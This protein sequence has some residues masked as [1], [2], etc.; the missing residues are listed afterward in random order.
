LQLRKHLVANDL[1]ND[2]VDL[3]L[4]LLEEGQ[5]ISFREL[6][7]RAP[8]VGRRDVECF[9]DGHGVSGFG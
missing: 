5:H 9:L 3:F 8:D 6:V 2:L 7:S 1:A 4:Q